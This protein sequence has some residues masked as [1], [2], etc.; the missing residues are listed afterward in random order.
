VA[1]V[2]LLLMF[3]R[4]GVPTGALAQ[5]VASNHAASRHAHTD[6]KQQQLDLAFQSAVADYNGGQY[7]QAAAQ[8]EEILPSLPH[9]FEVEELLGL[10]YVAMAQDA[11]AVPHLAAAA[12][13]KPDSE[14]AQTN[15]AA[16]L[17][18]LGRTQEAG[19]HFVRAQSLAP[20]DYS[21]NHNLG[22]FYIQ[23]NQLAKGIA[24]LERAQQARPTA[25]DNGYDLAMAEMLTQQYDKA[26]LL[27]QSLVQ[28]KD[29][30]ELHNL[31]GQID[32][33]NG[34]YVEAVNEFEHA[35]HMDASEENLFDWGSELLLHRT[36]EPA[37]EVFRAA[38]QRYPQSARL[39]IGLGMSLYARGLYEDSVKAL[40]TAADLNPTDA[41]CYLFLSRAYD[42]SPS[43]ADAV[44]QRFQRYAALESQN[45]RAQ[46]YYAMSLWK[47]KRVEGATVDLQKVEALLQSAIALD[48]S[49][50]EAHFQL[51]NLYA[52]QHHYEESV[53]QYQRAIALEPSLAE[54]HYRLALDYNRLGEKQQSQTELETYKTLRAAHLAAVD[55]ERSEVQQFIYS[56]KSTTPAQP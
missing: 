21:A 55:K 16:S 11:K 8:L 34:K 46:F 24:Y 47:G 30:G 6:S 41:R 7:P 19:E 2:A 36:Y 20:R 29:T 32:E 39:F 43:E 49:I 14:P 28:V 15:L 35:A 54:A 4:C 42:S 56:S 31:A 38:A 45:G 48:D 50:P 37:V 25:Y 1:A 33:K 44:I 5:T 22:E 17:Q 12:A 26:R 3:S 52:D 40:L 9:H 51:G 18:R 13:L 27:V 53:P 23:S 10:V